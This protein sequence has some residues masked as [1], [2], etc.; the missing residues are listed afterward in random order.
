[1]GKRA[2]HRPLLLE[3]RPWSLI[4]AMFLVLGLSLPYLLRAAIKPSVASCQ[5]PALRTRHISLPFSLFQVT[6]THDPAA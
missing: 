5:G 1:M 3:K 6:P 2:L 4:L